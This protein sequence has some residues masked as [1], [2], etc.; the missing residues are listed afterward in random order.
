MSL[1]PFMAL[2]FVDIYFESVK[3]HSL[4]D[5]LWKIRS[6][7]CNEKLCI[8]KEICKQ[9]KNLFKNYLFFLDANELENVLISAKYPTVKFTIFDSNF[10]TEPSFRLVATTFMIKEGVLCELVLEDR[11][12]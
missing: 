5:I 12:R 9:K 4:E 8:T 3:Y 6:E 1:L 10:N 7:F 11:E 2:S